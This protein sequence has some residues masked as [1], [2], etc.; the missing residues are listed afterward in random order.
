MKRLVLFSGLCLLGIGALSA[1]SKTMYVTAKTIEVKSSTAFFSDT[2]GTMSYGDPVSV[3]QEYGKW[4]KISSLEPPAISGWVAAASLTTKRIIVSAGTT[5]ASANEIALAGKGFN[6]QVE[7]VYRQNGT[8]NYDAIDAMEA[9]Q[10]PNR[11]LFAFL[12]EGR[13]ARGE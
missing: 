5:S 1:Q 10:I 8:L 3:L 6:Q 12:Q 11:Q 7:D 4:V 9:L 2:L 13:L